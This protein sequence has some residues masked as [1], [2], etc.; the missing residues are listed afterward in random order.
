MDIGH[1]NYKPKESG[2]IVEFILFNN[3][4]DYTTL[5]E[6]LFLLDED[7]Y[8][9][10]NLFKFRS[11]FENI[12]TKDSIIFLNKL[13]NKN[14]KIFAEFFSEYNSLYESNK[15]LRNNLNSPHNF[16]ENYEDS[17]NKKIESFQCFNITTFDFLFS[18]KY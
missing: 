3:F 1:K 17:L 14:N 18:R 2:N 4:D 7:N 9:N 11:E 10:T 12:K 8:F 6:C 15:N 16:K 5:K 13:N